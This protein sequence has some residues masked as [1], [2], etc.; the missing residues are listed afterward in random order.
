ML[1]PDQVGQGSPFPTARRDLT[2]QGPGGPPTRAQVFP[3]PFQSLSE[4]Q[5]QRGRKKR[6]LNG[7]SRL[8]S[9]HKRVHS[10]PRALLTAATKQAAYTT[11]IHPT[12]GMEARNLETRCQQ[13]RIPFRGYKEIQ[14]QDVGRATFPSE[15]AK[16]I[17]ARCFRLPVVPGIPWLMA[18]SP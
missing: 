7:E 11:G 2:S 10:F 13:G 8:G 15:A 9:N 3:R 12:T 14:N 18:A 4:K 5:G 6:C 16:T 17:F 1:R